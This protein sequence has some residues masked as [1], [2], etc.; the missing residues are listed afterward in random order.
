MKVKTYLIALITIV[1]L[2]GVFQEQFPVSNQEIV[3]Q[4]SESEVSKKETQSIIAL[5]KQQLYT[6]GVHYTQV[7]K[8]SGKLKI[9]YY[10]DI[11]IASIK[12]IFGQA[13]QLQFNI[14]KDNRQDKNRPKNSNHYDL[15]IYEIQP[16]LKLNTNLGL[17]AYAIDIQTKSNIPLNS[18][19]L[20]GCKTDPKLYTIQT[21]TPIIYKSSTVSLYNT[22]HKIPKVR[23]GPVA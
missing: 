21:I 2:L 11:D 17:N 5:I 12:K 22:L 6:V 15:S 16:N 4:F 8:D 1:T 3:L 14:S 7:K 9:S 23:A 13:H 10:S 19:N 18:L 20:F